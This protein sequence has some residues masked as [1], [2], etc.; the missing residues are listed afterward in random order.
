MCSRASDPL[1]SYGMEQ[2]LHSVLQNGLT[3]LYHKSLSVVEQT[4]W[5]TCVEVGLLIRSS[6]TSTAT[7]HLCRG[8]TILA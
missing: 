8:S 1:T 4:P 5:M 6:D 7:V 3:T 2:F